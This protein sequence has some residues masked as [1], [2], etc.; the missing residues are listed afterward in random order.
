[1]SDERRDREQHDP[2]D[3]EDTRAFARPDVGGDEPTTEQPAYAAPAP[4]ATTGSSGAWGDDDYLFGA[5][6][7]APPHDPDREAR[8]R[9]KR[10]KRRGRR[11]VTALVAA[12]VLAGA[13]AGF[14]GAAAYSEL[15]PAD[16]AV[17]TSNQ[18]VTTTV[19]DSGAVAATPG[20]VQAVADQVLP[21]VVQVLVSSGD[22]QGSGS[23]IILTEDGTI[24]TNAHVVEGAGDSASSDLV[25]SFSDGTTAP[26]EVIGEDPVTDIAVIQAEGVSG[27]QPATLGRSSNLQV[28]QNVVAIGSPFGL[29]ATVTTGIV[30]ALDRPVAVG[31][32]GDTQQ[33]T[34]YP[35]IQTDAAINPGNSG[36]PLVNLNGEVIG[37]NSSIR[38][39]GAALGGTSGSIGLGF[40]IPLDEVAPIISQI[41]NGEEPTH[42]L[43]GIEVS[44]AVSDAGLPRGAEVQDVTEGSAG[45]AAGLQEGDVITRLDEKLVEGSDSLVAQIRSLRPGEEV[46][47]GVLRDGEEFDVQA[48][49]GSDADGA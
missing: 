15:G 16:S 11:R 27:L 5:A 8:L 46:T 13:A 29:S 24:L 26:A 4:G 18:G 3:A 23:G 22:A 34:I 32:I 12:S 37:I 2:T 48:T 9:E 47:L 14:G 7:A 35:A 45:A 25:V 31:Q 28:G 39:G 33:N 1:M 17:S 21:S 43:I 30:S 19:V 40:A 38:T 49:L 10:E 6:A 20:S 42:A 44:D 36:G 41:R